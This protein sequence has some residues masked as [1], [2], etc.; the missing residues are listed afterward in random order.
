LGERHLEGN[1]DYVKRASPVVFRSYLNK[2]QDLQDE[3]TQSQALDYQ[4]C[5]D[6]GRDEAGRLRVSNEWPTG[7]ADKRHQENREA[8]TAKYFRSKGLE[9]LWRSRL[10]TRLKHRFRAFT[11]GSK[12]ASE[13]HFGQGARA[14]TAPPYE[15]R[16]I[17]W[18]SI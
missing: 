2:P 3:E 1:L 18:R 12:Q 17:V 9:G 11:I 16:S 13:S 5:F 6:P 10:C 4:G 8:F 7:E 15:A 14:N